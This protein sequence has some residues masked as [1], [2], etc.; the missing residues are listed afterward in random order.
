MNRIL[1]DFLRNIRL[2]ALQ[3]KIMPYTTVSLKFLASELRVD[4]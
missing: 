3:I 2:K 4:E 1:D